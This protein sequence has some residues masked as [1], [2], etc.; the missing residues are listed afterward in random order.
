MSTQNTTTGT[1]F[2]PGLFDK[3]RELLVRPDMVD[4]CRRATTPATIR[5]NRSDL[6]H[7]DLRSWRD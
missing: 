1:S 3:L 2:D 5:R 6:R 7:I 4:F